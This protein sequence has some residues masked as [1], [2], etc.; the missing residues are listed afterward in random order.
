MR[1][2][3]QPNPHAMNVGASGQQYSA[4]PDSSLCLEAALRL[5]RL[6]KTAS[7]VVRGRANVPVVNAGL[8]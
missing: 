7:V 5:L 1:P 3:Q 4:V 2:S 6:T 8:A